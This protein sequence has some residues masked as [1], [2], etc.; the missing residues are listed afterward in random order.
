MRVKSKIVPT[1]GTLVQYI[2]NQIQKEGAKG[3]ISQINPETSVNIWGSPHKYV[4]WKNK[5]IYS[6]S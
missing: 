5:K 1:P 4:Q 6:P 3:I 2:K